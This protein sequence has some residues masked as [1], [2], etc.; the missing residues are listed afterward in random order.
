MSFIERQA[1]FDRQNLEAARVILR[2]AA[3]YGGE[4]AALVQWARLVVAKQC[5]NAGTLFDE[6]A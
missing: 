6:A 3:R 5:E 1:A 4:A 2:D